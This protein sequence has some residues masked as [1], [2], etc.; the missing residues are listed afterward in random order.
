MDEQDLFAEIKR[1]N[2]KDDENIKQSVLAD[3]NFI[4]QPQYDYLY[5]AFKTSKFH[6]N[7]WNWHQLV[8]IVLEPEENRQ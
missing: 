6:E 3:D 4:K 5:R 8:R 7:G 2:S 1:L